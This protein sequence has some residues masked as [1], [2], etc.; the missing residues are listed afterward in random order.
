M[1]VDGLKRRVTKLERDARA[2]QER[3]LRLV[4]QEANQTEEQAMAAAG[5]EPDDA[6]LTVFIM[7]WSNSHEYPV[8]Q[9]A[10]ATEP[11]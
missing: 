10:A 4:F 1:N 6:F 7:R 8:H 11:K 2:G 5:V 3:Q 9:E